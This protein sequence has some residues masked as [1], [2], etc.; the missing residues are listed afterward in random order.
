MLLRPVLIAVLIYAIVAIVKNRADRSKMAKVIVAITAP[1]AIEIV[2]CISF[3]SEMFYDILI[4]PVYNSFWPQGVLIMIA[5]AVLAVVFAKF[6]M[7]YIGSDKETKLP[8]AALVTIAVIE[9]ILQTVIV[10]VSYLSWR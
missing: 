8:Q 2:L 10:Y 6:I 7:K 4:R 9:I 5:R 1:M 3:M